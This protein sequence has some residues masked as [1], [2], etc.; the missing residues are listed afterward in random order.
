MA[1]KKRFSELSPERQ[2]ELRSQWARKGARTRARKRAAAQREAAAALK[3][4]SP[5]AQAARKGVYA[6]RMRSGDLGR[7]FLPG[8]WGRASRV[9]QE[10]YRL[11][12]HAA[13]RSGMWELAQA[14]GVRNF[15]PRNQ[16]QFQ[17]MQAL[18][19]ETEVGDVLRHVL[20]NE[21]RAVQAVEML[22]RDWKAYLRSGDLDVLW[23]SELDYYDLTSPE[24]GDTR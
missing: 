21:P 14:N 3:A 15:G 13:Y 2:H 4:R 9:A 18:T 10:V 20:E 8:G 23:E 17:I 11:R 7:E 12:M 5:R 24:D 16:N 19:G 1:G 6:R 22:Q